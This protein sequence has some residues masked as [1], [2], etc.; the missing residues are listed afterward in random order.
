MASYAREDS[1]GRTRGLAEF[2]MDQ[3]SSQPMYMDIDIIPGCGRRGACQGVHA[4]KGN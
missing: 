3:L 2:L 4:G 1:V